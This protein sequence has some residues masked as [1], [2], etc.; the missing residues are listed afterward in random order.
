[1]Q[2]EKKVYVY[3]VLIGCIVIQRLKIKKEKVE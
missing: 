2:P 1:M 3:R